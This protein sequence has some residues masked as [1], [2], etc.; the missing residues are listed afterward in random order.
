MELVEGVELWQIGDDAVW[1][2]VARWLAELHERLLPGDYKG[3]PLARYDPA[4]FMAELA[5]AVEVIGWEPGSVP[6]AAHRTALAILSDE[7]EAVVHGDLFPANLLIE[8]GPPRRI[9]PVDWELAGRGPAVLDAAMLVASGW[10]REVREQMAAA[11]FGH[12]PPSLWRRHLD[13]G[14]LQVAVRFIGAPCGWQPP[15]AHRTDWIKVAEDASRRL[16]EGSYG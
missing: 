6:L 16:L 4:S 5:R 14:L 7:P 8:A 13:A 11:Y 12:R 1:V 15:A 10:S 9:V 2:E 3:V